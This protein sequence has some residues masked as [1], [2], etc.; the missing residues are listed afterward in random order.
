VNV[1][2]VIRAAT[3]GAIVALVGLL[4]LPAGAAT[5]G[6]SCGEHL[7]TNP[8]GVQIRVLWAKNGAV[9]RF[10]I[11]D[12]KGNTE[13]VNDMEIDLQKT[14]GPEGVNA[15]PLRIVSY[16]P[17]GEGGLMVPDKAVDSCGRTISF[18]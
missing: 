14:Y 5:T 6:P 11:V 2:L 15:P 13:D 17:G 7:F 12:S 9:Q 18:Q 1:R 16:K 3:V 8:Q 10:V 4:R